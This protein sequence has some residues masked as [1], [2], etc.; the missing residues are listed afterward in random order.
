MAILHAAADALRQSATFDF[1]VLE[2]FHTC[3]ASLAYQGQADQSDTRSDTKA[4]NTTLVLRKCVPADASCAR[5][6]ALARRLL[7]FPQG[8]KEMSSTSCMSYA[9]FALAIWN[10]PLFTQLH[11]ENIEVLSEA[12]GS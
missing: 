6:V 9:I 3:S 12:E 11:C 2:E 1:K 7:C 5:G 10:Y 8:P 4:L